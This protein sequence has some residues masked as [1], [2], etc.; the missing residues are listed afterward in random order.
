MP[1][2]R[3][4][5]RASPRKKVSVDNIKFIQAKYYKKVAVR[6]IDVVVIHDMEMAEKGDTAEACANY[7]AKTINTPAS[8]HYCADVDSIVQCVA[9]HD[10]AYAAPGCNHNG[11][12][13]EHAGYARQTSGDWKDDYST[14]MLN[15]SAVLTADICTRNKLPIEFVDASGLI[16]GHR[17]IT[18]H[19]EVSKAFKLSTHTDPGPNFPLGWYLE[20]VRSKTPEAHVAEPAEI[21]VNAAPIVVLMHPNW[22]EGSYIIVCADGGVFTFGGAPMLGSL[23]GTALNKP[24]VDARLTPS[25]NGLTMLGG[26]GGIFEFGDAKFSGRVT[27]N[28]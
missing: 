6:V 8:A 28:G 20:L 4:S 24:I 19:A 22:A 9:E 23:G 11:V 2:G 27:Y 26:D 10:V 14:A 18:T 5:W 25:G 13:I 17:G 12:H 15:M 16:L 7:F 21:V 3:L 1:W